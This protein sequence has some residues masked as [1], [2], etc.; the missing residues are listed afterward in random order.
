MR[1]LYSFFFLTAALF[2]LSLEELRHEPSGYAR[3]LFLL[4]IMEQ[5]ITKEQVYQAYFLTKSPKSAHSALLLKKSGSKKLLTL[6]DCMDSNISR[7]LKKKPECAELGVNYK[8]I[9]DL[10]VQKSDK[11]LQLSELIKE[12]A[13]QKAAKIELLSAIANEKPQLTEDAIGIYFESSKE[14]RSAFFDINL[15]TK[16][17]KSITT[18]KNAKRFVKWALFDKNNTELQKSIATIPAEEINDSETLFFLGLTKLKH[19]K[20]AIGSFVKAAK[21]ATNDEARDRAYF[22]AYLLSLDERFLKNAAVSVDVNFYSYL[23][24]ER[25]GKQPKNIEFLSIPSAERSDKNTSS[26][27]YFQHFRKKLKNAD[28]EELENILSQTKKIKNG[29]AYYL[30]AKEK[31][32]GYKREFFLLPYG[33]AFAD[34]NDSQKTLLHAIGRQESLFVPALVSSAYAIGV[35]QIIPLLA[36]ELAS[37]KKEKLEFFE[38]FEPT[39]NISYAASHFKWL[40]SKVVHPTLIAVSYNAGYGFFKKIEKNGLFV[41]NE[42]ALLAYEPFWS[43]ENIPYD[44]TRQYAK[45]VSLN[46]AV[47]S[48]K[49]GTQTTLSEL[50]EN[51]VKLRRKSFSAE[52]L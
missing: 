37:K 50:L 8:K 14:F 20:S 10:L 44:E 21:T 17:L 39:K 22:W 2:A 35:M 6:F 29:E 18:S 42:D 16:E 30:Y 36:E 23:A 38:L 13:P 32:D 48:K 41:F 31:Q 19:G 26:P 28:K 51:L 9:S 34:F 33:D 11:P 49:F 4:N 40:E 3:D 43:I 27:F 1:L 24:K 45:K 46:Y 52:A 47:Y 7:A 15:T 12:N 25:L 5:N